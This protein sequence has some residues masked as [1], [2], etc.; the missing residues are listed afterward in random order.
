MFQR[1]SGAYLITVGALVPD[2]KGAS[3]FLLLWILHWKNKISQKFNKPSSLSVGPCN[4]PI[5]SYERALRY[6][7]SNEEKLSIV[8]FLKM[9]KT[10]SDTVMSDWDTVDSALKLCATSIVCEFADTTLASIMEHSAECTDE[11]KE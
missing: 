8:K 1:L 6:N 11:H 2:G 4:D 5:Y 3:R 9:M 10:L 7:L